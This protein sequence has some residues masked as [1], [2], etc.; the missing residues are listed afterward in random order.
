MHSNKYESCTDQI[1]DSSN[2]LSLNKKVQYVTVGK[3]QTIKGTRFQNFY[4]K[5]IF[6]ADIVSITKKKTS[7][8]KKLYWTKP[9]PTKP[10]SDK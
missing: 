10:H 5:K 2:I 1:S 9:H 3:K 7:V 4:M 6:S 8:R